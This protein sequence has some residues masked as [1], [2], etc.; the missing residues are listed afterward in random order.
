MTVLLEVVQ[1]SS[2]I[3]AILSGQKVSSACLLSV[4]AF[5]KVRTNS[6]MEERSFIRLAIVDSYVAYCQKLWPCLCP[7]LAFLEQFSR[8]GEGEGVCIHPV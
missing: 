6:F 5:P 4:V 8:I 1:L 2:N 7:L 3:P